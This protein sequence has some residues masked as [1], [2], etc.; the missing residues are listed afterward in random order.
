MLGLGGLH[1][2]HMPIVQY[3]PFSIE[4]DGDDGVIEAAPDITHDD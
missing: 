1:Q 2:D 3:Q 4:A